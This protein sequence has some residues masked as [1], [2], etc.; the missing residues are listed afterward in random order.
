[1]STLFSVIVSVAAGFVFALVLYLPVQ[2]LYGIFVAPFVGKKHAKSGDYKTVEATLIPNATPYANNDGKFEAVYK[3]TVDGKEY[4]RVQTFYN[5][6]FPPK[7]TF[8]YIKNPKKAVCS[9][10]ALGMP[11][12]GKTVIKY[13]WA[14]CAV[15]LFIILTA[16]RWMS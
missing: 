10:D 15:I 5:H 3:Y 6:S 2:A 7:T 14:A 1:M 12:D 9:V 16:V 11:E 4:S 8:Y 13:T